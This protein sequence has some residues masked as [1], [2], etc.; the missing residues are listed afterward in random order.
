VA[1][2][3]RKQIERLHSRTRQFDA[4][5]ETDKTGRKR[6]GSMNE[7]KGSATKSTR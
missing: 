7:H 5:K 3:F 2:A 4:L 1:K 6:P